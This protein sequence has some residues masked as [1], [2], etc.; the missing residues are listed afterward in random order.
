MTSSRALKRFVFLLCLG[1]TSV[2]SQDDSTSLLTIQ[3]SPPEP[4]TSTTP[5]SLSA[6][7]STV[8]GS[9]SGSNTVTSSAASSTSISSPSSGSGFPE[10][11]A[12][13]CSAISTALSSCGAGDALNTTCLCTPEVETGYVSC[14]QCALSLTPRENERRVYQSI[15]DSYINQCALASPS[16]VTLPNMTITLPST[17]NTSISG[18]SSKSNSS[19]VSSTSSSISQ[20]QS[21]ISSTSSTITPSAS[22]VPSSS[23]TPGNSGSQRRTNNNA[24]MSIGLAG[25]VGAVIAAAAI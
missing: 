10:N 15:L 23:S 9:S 17:A 20:S 8:S 12:G 13:N 22:S 16:P 2:L 5:F 11:C 21:S 19:S 18:S 1:I 14:L 7:S 4:V 24:M 3:T 25:V 6:R